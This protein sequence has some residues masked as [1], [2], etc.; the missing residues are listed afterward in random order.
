MWSAQGLIRTLPNGEEVVP[1]IE[2]CGRELLDMGRL[3]GGPDF[4][5]VVL[6][7]LKMQPLVCRAVEKTVH[8]QPC[9]AS[10]PIWLVPPPE[11][12]EGESPCQRQAPR[13]P[14]RSRKA[15]HITNTEQLP[16]QNPALQI[17]ADI[18][19]DLLAFGDQPGLANAVSHLQSL[20]TKNAGLVQDLSTKLLGYISSSATRRRMQPTLKKDYCKGPVLSCHPTIGQG[21]LLVDH[22]NKDLGVRPTCGGGGGGELVQF[23]WNAGPCHVCVFDLVNNLTNKKLSMTMRQQK[24]SH[25]LGI[26]ALSWN[27]LV[28]SRPAEI[29]SN[30]SFGNYVD[31]SLKVVGDVSSMAIA[32]EGNVKAM[33]TQLVEAEEKCEI[34]DRIQVVF[35]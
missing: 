34:M 33:V 28:A 23:G 4:D 6:N 32:I 25:A 22:G 18:E 12:L 5:R 31:V 1:G 20:T 9:L 16:G 10:N 15:N 3:E 26:L 27:L 17:G 29:K 30:A 7:I 2:A 13:V 35:Q 19:K 14:K 24:D 21:T 11:R 8:L